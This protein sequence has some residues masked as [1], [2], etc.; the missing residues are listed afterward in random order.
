MTCIV[1]VE[2]GGKVV[3]TGDIQGSGYNTKI[4]H[5]QPKVFNNSGMAFGYTTSYRFGQIIEHS[6]N[7]EFLPSTDDQV[8]PWLVKEFVPHC[9]KV[10]T[11][12]GYTEGGTCLIGIRGQLWRLESDFAVLRSVNGFDAVGSGQEFALGALSTYMGMQRFE[13]VEDVVEITSK[14]IKSV[15]DHCPTVGSD[16]TSIVV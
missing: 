4:I 16:S 13:S 12:S 7:K 14:V 5:T 15:S 6:I 2:V 10:L 9:K 11:E 3:I 8:Y 1:G